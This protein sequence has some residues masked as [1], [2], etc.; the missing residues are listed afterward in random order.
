MGLIKQR[1]FFFFFREMDGR[2][3]F[4]RFKELGK[5]CYD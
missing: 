1:S 2:L 3:D 5:E 4:G